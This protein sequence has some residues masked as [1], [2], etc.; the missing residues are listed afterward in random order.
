MGL[1]FVP[2]N[3]YTRHRV[4]PHVRPPHCRMLNSGAGDS[5]AAVHIFFPTSQ[6]HIITRNSDQSNICIT[7]SIIIFPA[8]RLKSSIQGDRNQ[9]SPPSLPSFAHYWCYCI[10]TTRQTHAAKSFLSPQD[11]VSC[12][13]EAIR[14]SFAL[15]FPH[16]QNRFCVTHLSFVLTVLATMYQR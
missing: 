10:Y 12:Q 16:A 9:R 1:S 2:L 11:V 13:Q 14:L 15:P 7:L 4:L 8:S 5:P 6:F 3:E